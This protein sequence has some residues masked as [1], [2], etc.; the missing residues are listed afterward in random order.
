MTMPTSSHMVPVWHVT[1]WMLIKCYGSILPFTK[2]YISGGRKWVYQA[3]GPLLQTDF[4]SQ[5]RCREI[6]ARSASVYELH[7]LWPTTPYPLLCSSSPLPVFYSHIPI[8]ISRYP[9][10]PSNDIIQYGCQWSWGRFLAII[11][12]C[13]D[14]YAVYAAV[15]T[16]W[17]NYRF[18]ANHVPSWHDVVSHSQNDVTLF[19]LWITL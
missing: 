4:V 2:L 19:F 7:V 17:K 13:K 5:W 6:Y 15:L 12:V 9:V 18:S 8:P 10:M 16:E 1:I 11:G 3:C 14:T